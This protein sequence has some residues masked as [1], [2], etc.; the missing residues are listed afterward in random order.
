[1]EALKITREQLIV[2]SILVGTDY[3]QGG[4]KG[5]GPK[6]ALKLLH[7]HG[8]NFDKIFS[9]VKWTEHHSI[10]WKK[11]LDLFL[12]LPVEKDCRLRWLEPDEGK[13]REIL[14]EKHDFSSER[15]LSSLQKLQLSKKKIMQKGL[16]EFL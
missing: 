2:L 1:M 15:I 7:E 4:I 10:D 8:E 13:L 9:E 16:G 12:H 5:I 6:N 14:V 3:N 11:I